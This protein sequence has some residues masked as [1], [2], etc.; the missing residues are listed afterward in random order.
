MY[1]ENF[2]KG[3]SGIG[4]VEII[5]QTPIPLDPAYTD[6]FKLLLQLVIAVATLFSIKKNNDSMK[7]LK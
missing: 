3:V 2:V 6:I 4:A 5:N 1:I 7:N